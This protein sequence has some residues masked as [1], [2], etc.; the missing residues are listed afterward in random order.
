MTLKADG[1][2]D[3]LIGIGTQFN[4]TLAVYDWDKCVE[5]LMKRDEMSYEDAVTHMDFNVTGAYV[6][7]ETPVFIQKHLNFSDWD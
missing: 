5:I 3:A 1:F 2:E 4:K 6:G 7:E